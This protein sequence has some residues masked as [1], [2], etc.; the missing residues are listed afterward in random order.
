MGDAAGRSR[1]GHHAAA[2]RREP[3]EALLDVDDRQVAQHQRADELLLALQPLLGIYP[4]R[5]RG[6]NALVAAARVA[7]H[8]HLHARHTRVAGGGGVGENLRVDAVAEKLLLRLCEDGAPQSMAVVVHQRHLRRPL[9][10]LGTLQNETYLVDGRGGGKLIHL[11][12]RETGLSVGLRGR[13]AGAFVQQHLAVL[14]Q[15]AKV[16]V[17]AADH[18]PRLVLPVMS[19]HLNIQLLFGVFF[20]TDMDALLGNIDLGFLHIFWCDVAQHLQL[21]FRLAGHGA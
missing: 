16:G 6:G 1:G 3:S 14:R 7:H 17:F 11:P 4:Y 13:V 21:V 15:M 19:D 2:Q 18:H 10:Q 12:H 9:V 5:Q 20:L 8:G